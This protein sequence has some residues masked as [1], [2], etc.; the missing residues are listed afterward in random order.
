MSNCTRLTDSTFD[1]EVLATD[2]PVFVEFWG[3]WCPPCKMME[4]VLETLAQRLAGRV[5]VCKLNVDQHPGFRSAYNIMGVPAF[6]LFIDGKPVRRAI[7]AHSLMQLL[8]LISTA[9]VEQAAV[10]PI[11]E[12]SPFPKSA[13]VRTSVTAT[14]NS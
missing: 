11:V 7:G 4:P 8:D 12:V 1:A 2:G 9:L 10:Q 5:K 13:E 3:S 14:S 6:L